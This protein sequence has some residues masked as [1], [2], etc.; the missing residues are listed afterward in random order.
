MVK[1]ASGVTT[2]Q[3][4]AIKALGNMGATGNAKAVAQAL[5]LGLLKNGGML[6]MD[7]EVLFYL[8]Q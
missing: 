2:P 6:Q 8:V 1:K 7:G 3:G 4:A 5:Q